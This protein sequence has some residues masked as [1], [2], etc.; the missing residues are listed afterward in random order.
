M[1]SKDADFRYLAATL[2]PPPKVVWLRVGN[3]PTRDVEDLLRS[4]AVEIGS[5]HSDPT[6][7]VLELP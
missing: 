5:F 1:V 6:A 7:S 2:G 4:R 3:G